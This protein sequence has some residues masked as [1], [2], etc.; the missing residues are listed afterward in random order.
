MDIH[1]FITRVDLVLYDVQYFEHFIYK[2]NVVFC[3]QLFILT[4]YKNVVFGNHVVFLFYILI[5]CC[6]DILI[7]NT[8]EDV[9][10]NVQMKRRVTHWLN[11]Q[12]AGWLTV[13]S[14]LA[15]Y[16]PSYAGRKKL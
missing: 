5:N 7:R 4:L 14:P 15:V 13:R 16:K 2:Q 8:H 9:V 6:L 11:S 1:W 12:D 10:E 3:D